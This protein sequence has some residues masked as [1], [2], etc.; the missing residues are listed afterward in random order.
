MLSASD[1][2]MYRTLPREVLRVFRI[3]QE[4][5]IHQRFG[6]LVHQALERIMAGTACRASAGGRRTLWLLMRRRSGRVR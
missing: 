5:T 6:I 1:I 3:P 2:Y 4:P